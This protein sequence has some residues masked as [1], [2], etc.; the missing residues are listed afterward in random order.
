MGMLAVSMGILA[1]VLRRDLP[2]ASTR[3]YGHPRPLSSVV[4]AAYGIMG[5]ILLA[6]SLLIL[7]GTGAWGAVAVSAPMTYLALSSFALSYGTIAD[8][9][10]ILTS[11]VHIAATALAGSLMILLIASNSLRG[12]SGL[13]L[14]AAV[15]FISLGLSTWQYRGIGMRAPEA[16]QSTA[17]ATLIGMPGTTGLEI[18]HIPTQ[19]P[20]LQTRYFPAELQSKYSEIE[21]IGKGGIARVFRARRQS[22]GRPVAI[23][24]PISFDEITGISFLKEIR[25]WEELHH[26]NIVEVL[27]GN[28]LPLPYF[29]MEYLPHSLQEMN[30]PV[31]VNCAA[32]IVQGIASGLAYAHTRGVIHRD[33]KPH[34]I[35]FAEVMVPKI[36]DWGL[37]KDADESKVSSIAGFSLAYAAPE[38][39]SPREFGRT[40]ARTDI[41]QLGVIFY[42]LV[43]GRLPFGGEGIAEIASSIIRDRPAPPSQLNPAAGPVEGIIVKCLAKEQKERYQSV[44]EVQKELLAYL[45]SDAGEERE[46]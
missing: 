2:V 10:F 4:P 16:V 34:N 15:P 6:T 19:S 29:E 13:L 30:K 36:A 22:D 7:S 46:R 23:K 45:S 11:R 40:D 38:Q 14:M 43:T 18:D 33:L 12:G 9:P 21:Y 32:R 39:V 17:A 28:I 35:L 20:A 3:A 37:S 8:T 31:D 24:T 25:A 1:T 27:D 26:P 42:E 41:Y 5:L 44:E